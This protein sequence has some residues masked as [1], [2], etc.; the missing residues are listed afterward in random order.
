MPREERTKRVKKKGEH[1][2]VYVYI[3]KNINMITLHKHRT[4]LSLLLMILVLCS[5]CSVPK[6]F[7][8]KKKAAPLDVRKFFMDNPQYPALR[9]G[10]KITV[11]I[12]DHPEYSIGSINSPFTSDEATG[13]W[14][15]LDDEGEVNLPLLGRINLEGFNTKEAAYHLEK[16]YAV[17]IKNPIINVRVLNH[18]LTVMGEVKNPGKYRLDNEKVQLVEIIGEASGFTPYADVHDVQLLRPINGQIQTFHIDLTSLIAL[19]EENA[20][21]Q[22]D[23]VVYVPSTS[24]KDTEEWLSKAVPIVSIATGIAVLISVFGQN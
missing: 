13:R 8:G 1:G 24:K 17:H 15:A 11:S 5:S 12:W 20:V 14:I 23:D 2:I 21:L 4:S 18:F 16:K 9:P 10:D 3:P 7:V 22:P 19:E 6:L